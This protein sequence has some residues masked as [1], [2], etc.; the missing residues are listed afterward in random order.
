MGRCSAIPLVRI[1]LL[2]FACVAAS[3][4]TA[5]AQ[6]S[7]AGM[8]TDT[9]GAVL[10][11]VAVEA[12]SPALIERVR[13]GLT[14]GGGRYRIEEL[15]PG[16][17]TVTFTLPG[18]VT[19]RREAIP[20]T[21]T[22]VSTV[23]AQMRVGG[24]EE[25]I[26]VTGELPMV[27]VQS[28]VRQEVL[29]RAVLDAL[30]SGRAAGRLAALM[31][32]VT[33]TVQDV[34]GVT[35]DGSSRGDLIARGV[36]DS[37]IL[38]AG[39]VTQTG[40]GTSHGV[41]NVEA[42]QEV[43]VDTGAVS[44]EYYT[45][46]VRMNFIPRDGGNTFAG[47]FLGAFANDSMASNNFTQE[48]KDAGL[49]TPNTVKQLVDINPSFGG[50]IRKDRLWFHAAA[51]YSRA[52]NYASVFFN[53]NAGNPN[54]WTYEPDLDREPAA[55][56]NTIKNLDVRLTWQATAKNKLAFTFDPSGVC[57][58]PRRLRA[59]DSPEA[60]VGQY[61]H[62]S[63]TFGRVEWTSPVNQRVLL[64]ANFVAIYSDAARARI[65]PYFAPSPVPLIQVQE[66][67]S[68]MNYRGT[69]SAPRSVNAPLQGRA[70]MSYISGAHSFKVGFN[71]GT[72]DQR[73]ETF[74]P[75]SPMQF[76]FRNGVPNRIT[77]NATPFTAI[78]EGLEYG[79]F[80]Q[81]RWTINRWTLS[82]GLRY[83]YLSM[84]FPE[85]TVGPGAFTPNR[86]IVFPEI[87]GVRWHDLEPRTGLALDL[88]GDGR[89]SLK[90][91]LNKYLAGE[92]SGGSF[93]IGMAPAS[94]MVTSTTRSWA[95]ADGD[96][97]PD[98]DLALPARNGEC[99]ALANLDFGS[100]LSVL[101]FDKDLLE[102]WGKRL[103]NWQFSGGVQHALLPRAS[104]AVDYWRT[105]YGNFVAI[106][107]RGYGPADFDTFSI[108]APRDPRLPGGGGYVISGLYDVKPDA[109]GRPAAGFATR[110]ANFG[111]Q[112]EVWN[113]VDFSLKARP[114]AGIL[115][116][117]GTSTQKRSTNNCEI[118]AQVAAEAPPERGGTLPAYNPS[119]L[120]CDVPGKFLTQLKLIGS[121]TVPRID[122]E[123]AASLQNLPGP[124]LAAVYTA[125]NAQVQASLGRSLSGGASSVDVNLIEP[126]SMYGD[127]FS[128]LDLRVAKIVRLGTTR[129]TAG[130]D[131]YNVFNSSAVLEV[132]SA[133]DSWQQPLSI[134]TARFAKVVLQVNF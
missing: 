46:G 80:A 6:A 42:Y 110:A 43:A 72:I 54:V 128:Q 79:L 36:G 56:E 117:G 132:N 27:D 103:H 68:G 13:V 11:G 61:D 69:A 64:E 10:P 41:Y 108:T 48:L 99:G 1:G 115:V 17:Y 22:A 77:L 120:F 123:V 9:S 2:L 16:T 93:G 98:C 14:D 87:K 20:L 131:V 28:T 25:T 116:Q 57:D 76:R 111:K 124:A 73:R 130:L 40:T 82:A 85:Q 83:D 21:G 89:T 37:R 60:T 52:F 114:G 112:S 50:P 127:R 94:Q 24:L 70:V 19:I 86:N 71:G 51:R 7:I 8:V 74:S 35:G 81:D 106:D 122:V 4:A 96:Y 78:A 44:A 102:G 121:Y 100:V 26:T 62:D 31:P 90:V 134:L 118:V 126:R 63:R 59:T 125:S 30:P 88:F 12:S 75:D 107:H 101:E 92:G 38:I 29:D 67:S 113:G 133:F 49:G 119:Q 18:F 65:N 91:S 45:G 15:R 3:P 55:T 34:G 129:V 23:N 47:S 95:D 32:N 84:T 105:W 104:V 33:S 109:F 66:Q 97:V 5:H 58:C 53:K 39:L